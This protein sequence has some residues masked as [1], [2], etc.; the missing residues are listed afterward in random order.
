MA[1]APMSMMLF[2][3]PDRGASIALIAPAIL[4]ALD[5]HRNTGVVMPA[6][7]R[8]DFGR[9]RLLLSRLG[10]RRRR[11]QR[12]YHRKQ[13]LSHDSPHVTCTTPAVQ[14]AW[15]LH[16]NIVRVPPTLS[17]VRVT[18][19]IASLSFG[20]SNSIGESMITE[21]FVFQRWPLLSSQPCTVMSA[22]MRSVSRHCTSYCA[23]RVRS[24][25]T[26]LGISDTIRNGR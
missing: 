7:V 17:C 14:A 21:L 20:L 5:A 10:A 23:R 9:D 1:F 3:P 2:T 16:V 13:N 26:L 8:V 12:Q 15:F 19:Q 22:V 24:A 11:R 25:T 6:L 4:R 18:A